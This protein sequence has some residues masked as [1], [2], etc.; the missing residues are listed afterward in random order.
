MTT[1]AFSQ[2]QPVFNNTPGATLLPGS[3]PTQTIGAK[4][5]FQDVEVS[6]DG[7][8][9]DA[10]FT[11]VDI[12]DASV[13]D[14]DAING[15]EARFEPTNIITAIGG[16]VE[17]QLEFVLDGTVTNASDVGVKARLDSFTMEAIDVDGQEFFEA[18]VTNS[19]TL[20]GGTTPPT[21]L[22]VSQNG[23][24]TRFQSD[25]DF[26]AGIDEANT[27]Y[28][29]RINY[30]NVSTVNFRNGRQVASATNVRQNSIS[31]L[32][33][34]NFDTEN[35]TVVNQA[36]VVLDNLGNSIVQGQT[37]MGNI[38]AGASDP[39]N[40]E[41]FTTVKLVDP[42]D[43][44]NVGLPGSPLVIPGEGT[45]SLDTAGNVTFIPLP[46][47]TGLASALYTIE[48][49][50]GVESNQ[51]IL[52]I[53]VLPDGD[54][55]GLE[56]SDDDDDDNDGILDINEYAII[57]C[58]AEAVPSFGAAQGPN[59]YLGSDVT[60]PTVGDSYLYND[61]YP[62]VDAIVTIVSSTDT[63]I[64]ELDVTT[65]GIDSFFQPQIQ[66][67]SATSFTEFRIDFV[68]ADT[69]TPAPPA[70]YT[71]TAIDNDVFEY[72]TFANGY[73]N[74]VLVDSPTNEVLYTGNPAN[75]GGFDVGYVSDG[76]FVAGIAVN[77]PQYQTAAT[78]SNVSSFRFRFGDT[79]SNTSNHSMAI[80]PC[81]PE[82]NWVSD[83]TFYSEMDTDDD[84]TP[85]H[86]DLDSDNDGCF[87][88]VE[89]GGNDPD[90]DGVI[91]EAPYT[92]DGNGLVTGTNVTGGYD[93][94]NGN[95]T[96]AVQVN[97]NTAPTDQTEVS[98]DPASFTIDATADAATS[99]TAG[100]PS[101]GTPGNSNAGINYQW[102]IGDPDSGGTLIDGTDTNYTNFDT[103]TLNIAD[104]T[105]LD[106]TQ[107]CVV[108]THDNNVCVREVNCAE[109]FVAC[110]VNA[111]S[112][113]NETACND[114]NGTPGDVTDD[115]FTADITVTFN[116]APTTGTLDLSGDGTASVSVVGLTS[117][118]TFTSVELPANGSDISLTATFSDDTTCTLTN[119]SVVTAPNECSD[120]ACFDVV[121]GGNP[122]DALTAGD[123]TFNFAP[124]TDPNDATTSAML[125]SITIAGQPNPFS[126][127]YR[128]NQVMYQFANP[129]A[130]SQYIRDQTAATANII[131]GPAIFN[132][133]L[134][135]ANFENDLRHYLSLDETI[136]DT[137]FV[138][139]VYNSEIKSAS[140]RYIVITERNGNNEIQVQ[141]LDNTLS[142]FGNTIVANSGNY[143]DSGI[144]TDV[145]QNIHIAIFP[146]TALV[147]AGT[148]I[149]G[150][151]VTQIGASTNAITNDGGDGKVFILYDTAFLTPPPTINPSTAAIQPTCPDNEGSI[152]IDATDNGGGTLEYSVNGAAG[153]WQLSNVF[154]NLPPG[155]YTPAVRYQ[156]TPDCTEV[157]D[158]DIELINALCPSIDLVKSVL[159]VTTAGAPGLVDDIINYEFTVTNTGGVNLTDIAV[160]DPILGTVTC[161]STSLSPGDS[162]TCSGTYTVLQSDVDAGGVEN[163]ASVS[164]EGP[165]GDTGNT[166]D[167]VT[168]VSDTGTE[169]DGTAV[170][171]PANEE[172]DDLD[173]VNGDNNDADPTNDVTPF[174]IA[175][176][177]SIEILKSVSSV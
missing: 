106:G 12:V 19:Y 173:D 39:D 4:Y 135:A 143:I 29:V 61:V 47:F 149:Q 127:I 171:D 48:D 128:P 174:D 125:N 138:D 83:P 36:P 58:T 89:S 119:P 43:P 124:G 120:D 46:A 15:L 11:I 142:T 27:E 60:N 24:F 10:I 113:S 57:D 136:T 69:T 26:A 40:N 107:Y 109:L 126:G 32:G 5:I 91:G 116:I 129:G 108:V 115:I 9:V 79:S 154:N 71:L 150:I 77:T 121:Q 92:F 151:K 65:T 84:G 72:V 99:Y 45:Y 145:S 82:D 25:A 152:T 33:E 111:I 75:A 64:V 2:Q 49:D 76:S 163:S 131:D 6:A 175:P 137:D 14:V 158:S 170:A 66:H 157:S 176:D 30:S 161:L 117:P 78:Y 122:T 53:T 17:W 97:I 166:A 132:P 55:D 13:E 168:D 34:V 167:D 90:N 95:E 141:A 160:S 22:V 148:D 63:A 96:E 153:P 110:S 7:L 67:A 100:T 172:T 177:P 146:L 102:Y 87:D 101:Y 31:F 164:A 35:T 56:N 80:E 98:G 169:A 1:G 103:A 59:N 81:I 94:G 52:E 73:T 130:T 139:F 68:V 8:L 104:V 159:N 28:V 134:L 70:N 18:I 16:Y 21:E 38:L 20:E 44:A 42:N 93:G 144:I 112:S 50:L 162:T 133:A 156:S 140:N 114:V 23:A 105:G 147:P 165:G 86:L 51:G 41:D 37:F 88:A 118:H 74:N 54:G 85:D 155:T 62:G 123:V 3:P